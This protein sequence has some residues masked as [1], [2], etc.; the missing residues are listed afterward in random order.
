MIPRHELF[1]FRVPLKLLAPH[2]LHVI[3][4]HRLNAAPF[5]VKL[6]QSFAVRFTQKNVFSTPPAV[7]HTVCALSELR[8]F[9]LMQ[10]SGLT[11]PPT[12]TYSAQE[13][14]SIRSYEVCRHLPNA[15][16]QLPSLQFFLKTM[17]AVHAF[18]LAPPAH[19]EFHCSAHSAS[20]TE[21][22]PVHGTPSA[23]VSPTL[24]AQTPFVHFKLTFNPMLLLKELNHNRTAYVNHIFTLNSVV[25]S[26]P[27]PLDFALP[28]LSNHRNDVSPSSFPA[29][30]RLSHEL[31]HTQYADSDKCLKLRLLHGLSL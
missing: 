12:V 26:G 22:L 16:M 23:A 3:L 5:T 1:P 11:V 4:L 29:V 24:Y 20:L 6:C 19:V 21:Q 10:G 8:H 31:L 13:T 17:F 28:W 25:C 7:T 2:L 30:G 9:V 27:L 18:Q 15:R 14:A